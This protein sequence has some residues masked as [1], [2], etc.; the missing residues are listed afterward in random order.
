MTSPGL[1]QKPSGR[2]GVKGLVLL[3]KDLGPLVF[4]LMLALGSIFFLDNPARAEIEKGYGRE[5]K[6]IHPALIPNAGPK[7]STEAALIARDDRGGRNNK[8]DRQSGNSSRSRNKLSPEEKAR[9]NQQWEQW[10][11]LPPEKQ[12]ELRRRNKTWQSLPPEEKDIYKKRYKQW[13][14]LSPEEQ[15]TIRQKLDRWESL[16]QGEREQIRRKFGE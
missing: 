6:A 12:N 5:R 11:N 9:L 16:P 10:N 4:A 8:K 13:K 7:W 1:S 2:K 14:Q 3:I 15:R